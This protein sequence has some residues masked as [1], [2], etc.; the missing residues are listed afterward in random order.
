MQSYT[1]PDGED[2]QSQGSGNQLWEGDSDLHEELE[3]IQKLLDEERQ[4]NEKLTDLVGPMGRELET[5]RKDKAV[6]QGQVEACK[7]DLFRLRPS[8]QVPDSTIT[9]MWNDL[10]EEVSVW[11]D[12]EIMR[13]ETQS[14]HRNRSPPLLFCD[15]GEGRVKKYLKDYPDTGG[16]YLIRA[17]IHGLLQENLFDC[18]TLLFGLASKTDMALKTV[19]TSMEAYRPRKGMYWLPSNWFERRD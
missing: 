14:T 4:R 10:K 13:I 8:T 19:Q 18:D 7:D 17:T 3:L 12:G 16:E 5:L 2:S 1:F 6:L 15:G 9:Q 11:I